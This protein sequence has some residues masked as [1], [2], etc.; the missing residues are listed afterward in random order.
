ME[1]CA[2]HVLSSQQT[3]NGFIELRFHPKIDKSR[4]IGF[5]LVA[6]AWAHQ[7]NKL[8]SLGAY[9]IAVNSVFLRWNYIKVTFLCGLGRIMIWF[10][11]FS[12]SCWMQLLCI[13]LLLRLHVF[14]DASVIAHRCFNHIYPIRL[15]TR[16]SALSV[17]KV[18]TRVSST[19]QQSRRKFQE[20]E[21]A[22]TAHCKWDVMSTLCRSAS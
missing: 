21:F 20:L 15:Q 3:S 17:S 4:S 9:S 7:L 8:P 16:S 1:K 2:L 22:V 14:A 6:A 18:Y 12:I 5:P 19:H 10:Y 13:S 11:A